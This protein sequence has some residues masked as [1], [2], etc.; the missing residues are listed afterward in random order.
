MFFKVKYKKHRKRSRNFIAQHDQRSQHSRSTSSDV[1]NLA[2]ELKNLSSRVKVSQQWLDD[3]QK[4]TSDA[5]QKNLE[6]ATQKLNNM[7]DLTKQY[8]VVGR[9]ESIQTIID[10]EHYHDIVKFAYRIEYELDASKVLGTLGDDIV[11]HLVQWAQTLPF[12]SSITI[13]VYMH[14][15]MSKWHEVLFLTTTAYQ[16]IRNSMNKDNDRVPRAQLTS[17]DLNFTVQE[18]IQRL[19]GFMANRLRQ[20]T[21][22]SRLREEVKV[23]MEKVTLIIHRFQELDVTIEEYVCLKIILLLNGGKFFSIHFHY[24]LV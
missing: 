23:T 4:Y 17:Q 1:A 18:N 7:M 19:S 8:S 16:T 2:E 9:P 10:C 14:I 20:N 6:E 5:I 13:P 22:L 11:Y 15:L 24:T 3:Q 12:Q 21:P